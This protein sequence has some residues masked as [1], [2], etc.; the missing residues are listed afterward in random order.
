[1]NNASS[2]SRRTG[3]EN[4][5][6]PEDNY[7]PISPDT[8]NPEALTDF[9]VYLR[10]NNRFVLYTR[11]REQ[12]SNQLKERL[13]DNGIETV[14]IPYDQEDCYED[15]VCDNLEFILKD[16]AISMDVRS[17]VFLNTTARQVKSIFHD[18]LPAIDENRLEGLQHVVGSSLSFLSTPE[19]MENIGK[20]VSHDYQTFSHSV[21]VFTYTM[22]LMQALGVNQ[23]E[24]TLID[25]G[26]G[27][28]LHDIGKV[29]VPRA[30]LNKPGRLNDREW[31]SI[32]LHPV[33]GMR[34][35]ANVQIS[36]TSLNCIM[37]HHEKYNGT[38]YPS[39][40]SKAEIPLP[41]RIIA[42]CDVYDA[43]TS[44]RPY[45]QP[46]TPYDTLKI[47]ADEMKGSFDPEVFRTF[48]QMLG[49]TVTHGQPE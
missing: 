6:M 26:V 47:M 25:V 35:C 49:K 23:D 22:M 13:I 4:T 48:I 34:M 15:Y 46:Q 28:L 8:L 3:A 33:F 36:Q 30:I 7:F 45:S 19:A 41:A 16:P 27:A 42:C 31:V 38:G 9:K 32:K 20:F 11:E 2:G 24:Q 17:K 1:M 37:F 5:L 21:Q 43:L 40:M 44:K 14:Y 10:R 18:K 29:H 39:G 12:F